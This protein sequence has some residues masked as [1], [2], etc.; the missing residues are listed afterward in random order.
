LQNPCWPIY[1][2]R[3][4][5]LPAEPLVFENSLRRLALRDALRTVACKPP[6]R[7][8]RD[9]RVRVVLETDYGAAGAEI[10]Q[11]QPLGAAYQDRRFG[12]RYVNVEMV[13][14]AEFPLREAKG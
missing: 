14:P 8:R 7:G 2:G 12:L 6:I 11:D 9:N 13:D 5:Y 3:K 1:L 10:R 4:A